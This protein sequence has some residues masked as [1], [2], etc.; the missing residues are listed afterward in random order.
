MLSAKKKQKL[1]AA[2]IVLAAVVEDEERKRKIRQARRWYVRPIN[3]LRSFRG[4]FAVL[5]NDLRSLNDVKWKKEY[6]RMSD[7]CF[8]KLLSL[9]RPYLL[10]KQTH[11]DPILPEGR[12]VFTV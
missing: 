4:T 2:I 9:V 7:E 12:L 10:K 11:R 6:F 1:A 3:E 5:I 8:D